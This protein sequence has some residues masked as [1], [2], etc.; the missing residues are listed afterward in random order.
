MIC[1]GQGRVMGLC[2]V[3][4]AKCVGGPRNG[5][6]CLDALML[7]WALRTTHTPWAQVHGSPMATKDIVQ[8]DANFVMEAGEWK[9]WVGHVEERTEKETGNRREGIEGPHHPPRAP[10]DKGAAPE[11]TG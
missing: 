5:P 7:G 1:Y 11:T 8:R 6:R 9:L 2:C 4:E 10:T 3:V